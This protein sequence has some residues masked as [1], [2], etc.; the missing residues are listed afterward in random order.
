MRVACRLCWAVIALFL[1][2][3]VAKAEVLDRIVANVN[4]HIILYS[5]LLDSI[6]ALEKVSPEIKRDEQTQMSRV[7]HEVLQQM[8]RERLTEDEVKRLKIVVTDHEVDEALGKIRQESGATE[9]QMEALLQQQGKSIKQ[10]R[11][12]I[13]KQLEHRRLLDRVLK[14]KIVITDAQVDAY[15]KTGSVSGEARPRLAIIFIPSTENGRGKDADA[16]EKQARD[17]LNRLKGGA[18]FGKMA[19]EYSKGPSAEDGGDIGFIS[20]SELA[21][22]IQN[23]IRGL[24]ANQMTD[25]VKGNGGCYIIK[26]LDVERKTQNPTDPDLRE[27]VR[28]KLFHEE[29]NRRFEEWVKDLES[30][31]FIQISL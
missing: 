11:S 3:G 27:K 29:M 4:G 26:V 23:A 15:L 16:A 8:I 24:G 2:F 30:R 13:K 9:S 14:S 10:L 7:E 31:A 18:D 19:R 5:E 21:A 12:D 25:V 28:N 6:H 20:A 22:P 17:V 1:W